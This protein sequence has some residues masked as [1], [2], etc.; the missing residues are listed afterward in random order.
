MEKHGLPS[1][2][3]TMVTGCARRRCGAA[4]IIHVGEE[5]RFALGAS[6]LRKE[7]EGSSGFRK[8]REGSSGLRKERGESLRKVRGTLTLYWRSESDG[9]LLE[10][11]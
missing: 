1:A 4:Q 11:E 10:D 6:G 8:E 2:K 9:R 3:R 7:R 5:E